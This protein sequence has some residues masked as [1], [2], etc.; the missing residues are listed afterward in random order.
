MAAGIAGAF[1]LFLLFT[2]LLVPDRKLQEIAG[3]IAE[4]EGYTLRAVRFGKTF[5]LGIRAVGLEISN[6]RGTLLKAERA[7]VR[8]RLL[9]LFAGK[10][11]FSYGADIGPG[12]IKGDFS[13]RNS[14]FSIEAKGLHLEDIPFFPSVTGASVTGEL[15]FSCKFREKGREPGG[16]LRLEVKKAH[17]AG[18]KVGEMPLPDADYAVVQGMIRQ[19]GAGF[20]LESFTLQGDGLYVRLKG[21]FPLTTPLGMAPLNMTLDLMPKPEFLEKQK[22]VFLLLTKYLVSPGNYS[23]PIRG[24]LAKP[25][26]Q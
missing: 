25:L 16:E 13:P 5:P 17:I 12:L 24:V 22:F 26:I 8:L 21:D 20:T 15:S 4:R 19:K 2:L 6:D 11:I 14:E 3:R 18:V 7:S 23:I 9:P 1:L 10:A